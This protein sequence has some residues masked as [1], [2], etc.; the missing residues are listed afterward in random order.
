MGERIGR[1]LFAPTMRCVVV[2]V[3]GINNNAMRNVEGAGRRGRRPL[4]INVWAKTVVS[5]AK[6]QFSFARWLL[7]SMC[8]IQTFYAIP[9]RGS[10]SCAAL[11]FIKYGADRIKSASGKR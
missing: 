2:M 4:Q 11:P 10:F 6:Q 7:L 5:L 9:H 8:F 1:T 3:C